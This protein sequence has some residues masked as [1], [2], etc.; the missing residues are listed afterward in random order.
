MIHLY[1][2]ATIESAS[3]LAI[4]PALKRLLLD[5]IS[6]LP[7]EIGDLTDW[8]EFLVV[9]AG[10]TEDDI[11]RHIGFSPLVE[12]IEGK[13]YGEPGFVPGW[14]FLS[15]CGGWFEMMVTFG[16]AFAY[17]LLIQDTGGVLPTLR[18]MCRDF[19]ETSA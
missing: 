13:R 15:D 5:R 18:R 14:D 10:D 16:S 6:A 2:R 11:V 8:T 7:T 3:T 4:D 12:P 19:S 1:D 17:V 9:E